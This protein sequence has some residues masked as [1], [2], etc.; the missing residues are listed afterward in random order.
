MNVVGAFLKDCDGFGSRVREI[1]HGQ[2]EHVIADADS[3]V[4]TPVAAESGV[5]VDHLGTL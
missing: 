4:L 3:T 1:V 2:N 5:C